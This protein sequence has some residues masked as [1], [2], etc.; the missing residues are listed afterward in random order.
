MKNFILI[1]IFLLNLHTTKKSLKT[2]PTHS[3]TNMIGH[4]QALAKTV[5]KQ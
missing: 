3:K 5:D 1:L 2:V 4:T